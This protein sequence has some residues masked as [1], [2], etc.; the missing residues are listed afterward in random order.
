M[1]LS[2]DT[3]WSDASGNMTVTITDG[4]DSIK[5]YQTVT[6]LS[7]GDVITVTGTIGTYAGNRQILAGAVAEI[8]DHTDPIPPVEMSIADA[9]ITIDGFPVIVTGSVT[10]VN[11]A[12]NATYGNMNVT[13]TDESGNSLY[14]YR[15]STQVSYGDVITVTGNMA[16]FNGARQIA[17]G[18]T[19]V[20]VEED[21]PDDPNALEVSSLYDVRFGTLGETYKAEGVVVG[22]NA[23]SFLLKD[24]SGM[25][26]VYKGSSWTP[27]VAIGDKLTV[28]G[29]LATYGN[30]MQFGADTVYEK[31]GTEA[32]TQPTPEEPDAAGVD[33]FAFENPI[34]PTYV[35]VTGVLSIDG[36]YYNL[37]ID[38]AT[39]IGSI[40]YP[41]PVDAEAL[42]ALNGETVTVTGYVTGVASGRYLSILA[43][44]IT[45]AE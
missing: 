31:N 6:Q 34:L 27:D 3:A 32:V 44:S 12:W 7:L 37:T 23:Q 4:E 2:I 16:T 24:T 33:R 38:G 15:L 1:V 17:Q 35:T 28:T 26:L 22:V 36:N 39:L 11:G 29:P 9:L 14:L 13:I 10:E 41:L 8:T 40:N 42:A 30:A 21:E 20:I 19:A 25:M 5:I 45:A 18:A 43:I